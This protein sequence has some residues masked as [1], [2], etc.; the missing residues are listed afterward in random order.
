MIAIGDRARQLANAAWD[1]GHQQIEWFETKEQ[2]TELLRQEIG[3]EDVVLT[4]A[5]HAQALETMVEALIT[6]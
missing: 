1:A 2:A 6:P 5:S 3:A 4:K